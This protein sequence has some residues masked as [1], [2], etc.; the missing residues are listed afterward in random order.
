MTNNSIEFEKLLKEFY[1]LKAEH[2][3]QERK[4]N[5]MKTDLL[6]ILESNNANIIKTYNYELSRSLKSRESISKKNLPTDIWNKYKNSTN[7][8]SL[9]IKLRNT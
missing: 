3:K 7:F 2:L 9:N 4:L 5:N 8:Y 6:T 1:D